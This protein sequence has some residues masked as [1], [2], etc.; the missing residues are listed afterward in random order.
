MYDRCRYLPSGDSGIMIEV[1]NKISKEINKKIRG[2]MMCIEQENFEEVVEMIPT[3]T[4]ILLIYNPVKISYDEICKKLMD[5]ENQMEEV[6][7][8]EPEIIYIPTLYGKEFGMDIGDVAEHNDLTVDEVIRIH[9]SEKYLI[10]M[11]GFTPGYPYLGGMSER[12]ATPRLESP[13]E[14][15]LAGSVGIA[16]AQTG[17]Y[18]IDSPGGWRIIGRTPLNLFDQERE[19]A[20]L[21]KA[22][23]YLKFEPINEEEYDRINAEVQN[24]SY[25]IKR[26]PLKEVI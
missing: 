12:I 18:P 26:S 2:L 14:R 23:Q 7:L 20:V 6:R 10:Y 4:S 3:Y 9:S 21:L 5:L 11:L 22:G 25:K 13:R 1:G 24:N 19:P 16:G 8:S 17:I 15:V